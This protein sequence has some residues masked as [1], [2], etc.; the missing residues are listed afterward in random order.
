MCYSLR[1]LGEPH[2]GGDPEAKFP[3][4][5]EVASQDIASFDW[6]VFTLEEMGEDLLLLPAV[7]WYNREFRGC[8]FGFNHGLD[9]RRLRFP[10]KFDPWPPRSSLNA[11]SAASGSGA[12]NE[13]DSD[14]GVTSEV[15]VGGVSRVGEADVTGFTLTAFFHLAAGRNL[16]L[17]LGG[18][19]GRG[20]HLGYTS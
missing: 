5:L 10:D 18:F 7:E 9:F 16:P 17:L 4:D 6:V 8:G 1:C 11:A 19:A 14:T 12:G 2:C 3:Q 20:E 13:D 15:G